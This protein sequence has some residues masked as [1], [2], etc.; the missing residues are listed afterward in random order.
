M[1]RKL[2][3]ACTC[4][5]PGCPDT[6]A[7]KLRWRCPARTRENPFWSCCVGGYRKDHSKKGWVKNLRAG[8]SSVNLKLKKVATQD[9]GIF[10]LKTGKP[11]SLG[12]FSDKCPPTYRLE[13]N[14]VH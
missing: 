1:V 10:N 8:N 9:Y 13:R 3:V 5:S 11:R 14:A 4:G 2:G 12:R 7:K 6:P